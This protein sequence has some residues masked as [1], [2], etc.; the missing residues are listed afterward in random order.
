M[1]N[2]RS[3][4]SVENEA[5]ALAERL[6]FGW[7]G[8]GVRAGLRWQHDAE[9]VMVGSTIIAIEAWTECD[10][11]EISDLAEAQVEAALLAGNIQSEPRVVALR[12]LIVTNAAYRLELSERWPLGLNDGD[13]ITDYYEEGDVETQF[14]LNGNPAEA[15]R[16]LSRL[17]PASVGT[18]TLSVCGPARKDAQSRF[19]MEQSDRDA[20]SLLPLLASARDVR[21]GGSADFDTQLIL[22]DQH[23]VAAARYALK[24]FGAGVESFAFTPTGIGGYSLELKCR[25]THRAD[26]VGLYDEVLDA[27]GAF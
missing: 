13:D 3:N 22:S 4:D 11:R 15:V 2:L 17:N 16:D 5:Q 26:I 25:N 19:K 6:L 27:M 14:D 8:G 20:R 1:F 10:G 21:E 12:R 24:A 18:G 7:G 23:Y 9:S